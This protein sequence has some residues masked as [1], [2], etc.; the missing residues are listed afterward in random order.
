VPSVALTV[1]RYGDFG[2]RLSMSATVGGVPP[3]ERCDILA[4][5]YRGRHV[6]WVDMPTGA[7]RAAV[8][9]AVLARADWYLGSRCPDMAAYPLSFE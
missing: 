9:A 3:G 4:A 2:D 7:D 1:T 8:A 6:A 5:I